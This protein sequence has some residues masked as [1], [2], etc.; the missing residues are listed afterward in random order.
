MNSID[1]VVS[2]LIEVQTYMRTLQQR[3]NQKQW[4]RVHNIW[5]QN[6][7]SKHSLFKNYDIH[8]RHMRKLEEEWLIVLR[9]CGGHLPTPPVKKSPRYYIRPCHRMPSDKEKYMRDWRECL[10]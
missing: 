7:V 1:E 8:M 2:R 3:N 5:K 10:R 6:P 9:K 4:I